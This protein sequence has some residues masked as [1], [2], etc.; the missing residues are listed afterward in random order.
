MSKSLCIQDFENEKKYT[1]IDVSVCVCVSVLLY[2]V[3]CS[4]CRN[5]NILIYAQ[6]PEKYKDFR[7]EREN[8]RNKS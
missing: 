7:I 4:V 6:N 1:E 8:E 3:V 5:I 2:L